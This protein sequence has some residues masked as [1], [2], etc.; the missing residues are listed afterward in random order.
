MHIFLAGVEGTEEVSSS[1]LLNDQVV[2]YIVLCCIILLLPNLRASSP[3]MGES[4]E[5]TREQH[6][7]EG[8]YRSHAR[9][10]AAR[11]TGHKWRAG[12]QALSP[13][14]GILVTRQRY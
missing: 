11:F 10:L 7:S 3:L 14:H 13:G 2:G 8:L 5:V 6:V 4:R 12:P 9:S 1:L